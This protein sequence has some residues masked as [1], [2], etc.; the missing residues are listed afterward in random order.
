M[1]FV[2]KRLKIGIDARMCGAE[3][4]GIGRMS[5]EI[6]DKLPK[7]MPEYD[8]VFFLNKNNFDNLEIKSNNIKKVIS[9][10]KIYSLSEQTSFLKKLN[11]E[12]CDLVH[13]LHFNVPLFYFGKFTV[14]IHDLTLFDFPGKKMNKLHHRLAFHSIFRSTIYKAK[15]IITVS[16][17]TKSELQK[18]FKFTNQK[19]NV[20]YNGISKDF[21]NLRLTN[22]QAF[23]K[24]KNKFNIQ[25]PFFLYTGV[26][27]EHKN[28]AGLIKA[29][30]I[31]KKQGLEANLVITGKEDYTE[32]SIKES[33]KNNGLEKDVVLTGLVSDA[34][35]KLLF[36]GA[37]VFVFPSFAEGFGIP[38][39]EAMASG[40]PVCSSNT[41]SLPEVCENAALFFN[42][43]NTKDIASK[44]KQIFENEK[45]RKKLTEEGFKQIK[46]F[47]WEKSIK[48]TAKI[49]AGVINSLKQLSKKPLKKR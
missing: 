6:F 45:L 17:Y 22:K 48:E 8:F 34:D 13:F 11:Q 1:F 29:F 19:I 2:K 44:M 20:V 18:H 4:T 36:K 25:K 39:L 43:H 26:W 40:T 24:V 49:L 35:L 16:E 9:D 10:E 47:S 37:K 32:K 41:T 33:I 5:T 38:P 23:E 12:K 31:L 30:A 27:R 14:V 42:P 7:E 21:F 46:K 3:F 15:K 28:L